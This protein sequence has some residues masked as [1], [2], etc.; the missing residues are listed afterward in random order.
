M[1]TALKPKRSRETHPVR[2]VFAISFLALAA[3]AGP[4][5]YSSDAQAEVIRANTP[6][7]GL[8][9]DRS[10]LCPM[11]SGSPGWTIWPGRRRR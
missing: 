11:R 9:I 10:A 7:V 8:T 4:S 1:R 3:V 2:H 6:A 5:L